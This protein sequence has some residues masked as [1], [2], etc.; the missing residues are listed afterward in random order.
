MALA[1]CAA[2]IISAMGPNDIRSELTR[3]GYDVG[4]Q[5]GL[6]NDGHALISINGHMLRYEDAYALIA[7]EKLEDVIKRRA[8]TAQP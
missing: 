8:G 2:L 7:G 1:G 3:L 6:S 4:P 5:T